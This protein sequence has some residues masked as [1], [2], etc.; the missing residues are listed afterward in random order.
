MP[1]NLP[2]PYVIAQKEKGK[3]EEGRE[4]VLNMQDVL[5]FSPAIIMSEFPHILSP[6]LAHRTLVLSN[7]REGAKGAALHTHLQEYST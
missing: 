6:R 4:S 3:S 1:R 2:R 7:Q 5:S